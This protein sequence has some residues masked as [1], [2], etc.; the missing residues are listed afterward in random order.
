MLA[1]LVVLC[2]VLSGLE[3]EE[4][5]PHELVQVIIFCAAIA[6]TIY[7]I[8]D[9][10]MPRFGLIRVDEADKALYAVRAAMGG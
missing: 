3:I 9:L 2:S 5:K 7:M 1:V 10:Y 8:V 6:V 4:Y